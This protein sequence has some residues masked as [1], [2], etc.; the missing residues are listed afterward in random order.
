MSKVCPK[1]GTRVRIPGVCHMTTYDICRQDV[2]RMSNRIVCSASS[3]CRQDV[4]S[5]VEHT[6]RLDVMCVGAWWDVQWDVVYT[7]SGGS[8]H[9]EPRPHRLGA[10]G[11]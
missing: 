3:G 11:R 2:V 1:E 4:G 10:P 9:G 7:G 8:A 5:Y 6:M